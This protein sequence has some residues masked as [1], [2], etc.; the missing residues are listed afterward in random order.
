M[1]TTTLITT[2]CATSLASGATLTLIPSQDTYIRATEGAKGGNNIF[3]VGD[4][5][6]TDDFLRGLL[7]F[8]LS[9]P[10][11]SGVTITGVELV[12][13]AESDASSVDATVNL[14]LH[15]LTAAYDELNATWF[16]RDGTNNWASA[17]GDFDAAALASVS[18]NAGTIA[19]DDTLTFS[20]VD[21]TAAVQGAIGGNLDTLLKLRNEDA[22]SRNIF[23]FI[24]ENAVA[25]QDG[26]EAKL[27]ITYVPEPGTSL[28]SLGA[29]LCAFLV[30]RRS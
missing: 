29:G 27:I 3:L 13:T 26:K 7:S 22:T 1:K 17:G 5:T 15:S 10:A 21:L 6:N 19:T 23:R 20:S 8:D 12:L 9:D 14:D 11:L 30:R 16:S 28:L 4:T 2:L 24:A 18:T 25:P